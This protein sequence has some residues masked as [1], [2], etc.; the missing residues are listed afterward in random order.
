MYSDAVDNAKLRLLAFDDRWHYVAILCLKAEGVLD[1]ETTL[2]DR[3]IAIKLGLQ[4]SALDELKRRLIEVNLI[5][6]DFQP[7]GW[8]DRQY[9]ED[10]AARMRRY[11]E[12]QRALRNVTSPV[13]AEQNRTDTE[14]IQKKSRA[15]ALRE[16]VPQGL[17]F[18][19]W[20]RFVAYR[21]DIRKPLK[22]A[23]ILAAQRKLA[24]FGSDQSSVVEQSVA[25]GWT[26]IFELKGTTNGTQPRRKN[27]TEQN[28]D[29]YAAEYLAGGSGGT[30]GAESSV[31]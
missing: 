1:T 2:L 11:R 9:V 20:E 12:K 23:S 18:V 4:V 16:S 17:D 19:S 26:G 14:Q 28:W 7:V 15:N 21:R 29:D 10:S 5:D 30:D 6:E 8:E 3:L 22:P 13:T 25:N 31:A 27:S 24:G